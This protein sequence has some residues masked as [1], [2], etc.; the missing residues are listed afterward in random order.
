MLDFLPF[1]NVSS[2]FCRLAFGFIIF[3]NLQE[4][5]KTIVPK[6]GLAKK[7]KITIKGT[8]CIPNRFPQMDPNGGF[9]MSPRCKDPGTVPLICPGQPST[10]QDPDAWIN[11]A[12]GI[13]RL[14]PQNSWFS[15][16]SDF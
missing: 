9:P 15:W 1:Q 5:W 7:K 14:H 4:I 16:I 12:T 3:I 10:A 8:S 6:L 2:K 13:P 11:P